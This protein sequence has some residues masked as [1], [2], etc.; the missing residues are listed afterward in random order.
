MERA[1]CSGGEHQAAEWILGRLR[2]RGLDARLEEESAH[3]TY[4]I[5][6]GLLSA[7]G[8]L[9]G[10]AALRGRRGP[11]VLG[12]AFAAAGIWSE[13]GGGS[14][15]FR[16]HALSQRRTWNV[17][18]EAGDPGAARTVV[19]LAHHD[20]ARSGLIFHPGALKAVERH[21]PGLIERTDTSPPLLVPVFLGPAAVSA[22]ALLGARR[23]TRAGAFVSAVSALAFAQIGSSE[24]VPGAN[25]NLTGVAVLVELARALAERPVENLRVILLSC[26]SEESFQEGVTAFIARHDADLAPETT[27]VICVDTVGSPELCAAEG[28]GMLV[29]RDYDSELKNLFSDC[30]AELGIGMRRGLRFSFSSDAI[31]WMRRGHRAMMLGSINHRRAPSNYHWPSDHADN[32]DY[33]RVAD[34]TRLVESAVRRLAV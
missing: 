11:G 5:P 28:E 21:A 4:W 32:V 34:A 17:V 10:V 31:P 22:G 8:A 13:V 9:A 23:L 14:Q 33:G 7:A 25:D 27:D 30:A 29:M 20:A 16:R 19:V 6:L 24:T 15:W 2:D 1:S 3:G 26:G 12:G 18:A